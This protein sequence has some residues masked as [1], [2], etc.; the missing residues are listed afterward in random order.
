MF[1]R[2]MRDRLYVKGARLRRAIV[3]RQILY[4]FEVG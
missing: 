2:C 1:L 4:L 3:E